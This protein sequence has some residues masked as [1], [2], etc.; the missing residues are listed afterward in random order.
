MNSKYNWQISVCCVYGSD[1]CES[2]LE[3]NK[4]YC[5]SIY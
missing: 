4:I 2:Y 5:R 3:N 1:I